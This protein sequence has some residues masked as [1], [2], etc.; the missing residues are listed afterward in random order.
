MDI[1]YIDFVVSNSH[2]HIAK[3]FTC[4]HTKFINLFLVAFSTVFTTLKFKLLIGIA[5]SNPNF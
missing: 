5:I 4:H 1:A 2:I 3:L